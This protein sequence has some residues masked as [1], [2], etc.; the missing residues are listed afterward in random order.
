MTK[1]VIRPADGCTSIPFS[2]IRPGDKVTMNR[3]GSDVVLRGTV[4]QMV[5]SDRLEFGGEHTSPKVTFSSGYWKVLKVVRTLPVIPKIDGLYQV[6]EQFVRVTGERITYP[7]MITT[8][9]PKEDDV[10]VGPLITVAKAKAAAVKM[11]RDIGFISAAN[12]LHAKSDTEF[13][14]EARVC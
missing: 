13:A 5:G 3:N 1:Q 12:R 7:N 14:Q 2:D 10:F 9:R 6:G 8:Y 4:H 11:V